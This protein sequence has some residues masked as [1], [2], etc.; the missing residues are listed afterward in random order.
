L[1]M[2]IERPSERAES[3]RRFAPKRTRTTIRRIKIWLGSRKNMANSLQ[4]EVLKRQG[5]PRA[6]K[7]G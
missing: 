7:I 4:L 1:N 5:Y 3:G 2:R 6:L